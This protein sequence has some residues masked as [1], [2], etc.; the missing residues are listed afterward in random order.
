MLMLRD[1]I[2]ELMKGIHM[3]FTTEY[4]HEKIAQFISFL[5]SKYESRIEFLDDHLVN[6]K[7]DLDN[8]SDDSK[9]FIA[10]DTSLIKGLF[11]FDIDLEDKSADVWGPFILDSDMKLSLELWTY[12]L[13]HLHTDVKE[14][15]FA[16][17]YKNTFALN[18]LNQIEAKF[19]DENVVFEHRKEEYVNHDT[20]EII[21]VTNE[22][23]K[24]VKRLHHEAF[25]NYSLN[26]EAQENSDENHKLY[27]IRNDA[28]TVKGYIHILY[29]PDVNDALINYLA[30]DSSQ[31]R[32]GYAKQLVQKALNQF[33][34][35]EG[36]SEC[37]LRI[38][39]DNLN[40]EKLYK[41]I[42]FNRM[43]ETK[44]YRYNRE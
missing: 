18:F 38:D 4:P 32:K 31:R 25:P 2:N 42:G 16:I 17:N 44:V 24:D 6:I 22:Y 29:N 21:E 9:I 23:F 14:F 34:K 12:A 36:I 40:A 5:N 8:L 28:S 41:S 10:E 39:P 26:Y 3:K 43:F 19:F 37:Y 20:E 15:E 27:I 11:I 7:N 13:S 30:V 33:Y 1:K 35:H